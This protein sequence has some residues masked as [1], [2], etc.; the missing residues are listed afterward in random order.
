MDRGGAE[1]VD[2]SSTEV[3]G[4]GATEVDSSSSVVDCESAP[5]IPLL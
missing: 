5:L 1:V 3:E 4:R 2:S